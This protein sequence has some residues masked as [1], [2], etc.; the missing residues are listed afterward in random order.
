[1]MGRG[2]GGGVDAH[3]R[4]ALPSG[5][6]KGEGQRTWSGSFAS[7]YSHGH[8]HRAGHSSTGGHVVVAAALTDGQDSC[9]PTC[10]RLPCPHQQL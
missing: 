1:M 9:P 2:A 8:G 5:W 10:Q 6:W 7:K 3:T 4:Q